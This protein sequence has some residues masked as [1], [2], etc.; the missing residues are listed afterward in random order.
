MKKLSIIVSALLLSAGVAFAGSAGDI[1]IDA[2]S[3]KNTNIAASMGTTAKQQV[4][5][6]NVEGMMSKVGDVTIIGETEDNT[7]QAQGMGSTAEQ[8]VQSVNVK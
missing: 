3:G 5:S 4:Q 7:N 6:V 2:V 1:T 8:Q